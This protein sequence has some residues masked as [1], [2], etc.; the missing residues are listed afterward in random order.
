MPTDQPCAKLGP[1]ARQNARAKPRQRN[2]ET[3]STSHD[4]VYI[5]SGRLR[6]YAHRTHNV[7]GCPLVGPRP[8]RLCPSVPLPRL[9][10]GGGEDFLPR[11]S[12]R[13]LLGG[14]A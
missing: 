1:A 13:A 12:L 11:R 10:E 6:V 4:E 14:F 3:T 5:E 9:R 8:R 2:R 7:A